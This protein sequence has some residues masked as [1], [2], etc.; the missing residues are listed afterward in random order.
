M[1]SAAAVPLVS[2]APGLSTETLLTLMNGWKGELP[3]SIRSPSEPLLRIR[4]AVGWLL[5]FETHV[6]MPE[7]L[8]SP[9]PKDHIGAGLTISEG[10]R[11]KPRRGDGGGGTSHPR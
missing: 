8:E 6:G 5:R 7:A 11:K 2:D 10:L 3:P 9:F 4:K 1:V